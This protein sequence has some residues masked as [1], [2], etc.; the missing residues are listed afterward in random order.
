MP[1]PP[2]EADRR[3]GPRERSAWPG[4]LAR[5]RPWRG[6]PSGAPRPAERT[7]AGGRTAGLP[8]RDGHTDDHGTAAAGHTGAS[9]TSIAGD[10]TTAAARHAGALTRRRLLTAGAAAAAGIAIAS[11]ESLAKGS[12][13]ALITDRDA[14]PVPL[15][16]SR[17]DLRIP[18]LTVSTAGQP[19]APGLLLLAPYNAP[20]NAQ[21][22]AL[23]VDNTGAPVWE[24]PLS[25]LEAT[26]LRV[27]T[28]QGRP[29]LTWWQGIITLGHGVGGYVIADT[30]YNP[31]AHV[32][33]VNGHQGDLH[34]FL[35]TSRG[36]VL[37]TSYLVTRRDLRAV[38][39][40]ANGVIQDALF[41]EID[42]ATGRLL[43]EWHSL[44]HIPITESYW[45]LDGHWDFVHLNSIEVDSDENLL[46][47]CRNTH[48]IYKIDRTTGAIIWRL[49][50][51]HSDFGVSADAAF[52][53]Q[54]DARRQAD[55]TITV[56]D[57]GERVSRALSL[58]VDET[59]RRVT[60]RRA[61]RH[62]ANLF[63]SSQG[64]VQIQPN[65]NVLVGW[66]AQPYIS[67]FAPSGEL[68]F[69]ARLGNGYMSYR[70][71]RMPWIGSGAGAPAVATARTSDHVSIWVS[72]N[73]DTRVRRWT[74][75]AGASATALAPVATAVRTGFETVLRIS[76]A[77]K[78]LQLRGTDATGA[79]LTSTAPIAI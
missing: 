24:L 28:Y 7:D 35:I 42:I 75:L 58:N 49:G 77:L 40:S 5:W 64:N 70:A 33:A 39:G 30:A 16:R 55:G 15:F 65:G 1:P 60:L 27:Q 62:P 9:L 3:A 18:A 57:N 46:V 56:F 36:T 21:A 67:E 20:N 14:P 38:G 69:D 52:A 61:Y 68:L 74:A 71:F 11:P 79:V 8:R 53:W 48:T 72:W 23:I 19:V 73:G 17:P 54:H 25:H 10:H 47:S 2:I 22:G 43:L 78:H 4:A 76:P 6:P 12:L 26:D 29:V 13:G 37:L 45:P 34:E 66:G 31:I 44:D 59:H 63:A 41:Q 32:N 50:G 51:K